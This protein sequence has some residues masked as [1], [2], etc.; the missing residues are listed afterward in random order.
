M[1]LKKNV[2]AHSIGTA[3]G[4]FWVISTAFVAVFPFYSIRI[5]K[6]I[7]YGLPV[8]QLGGFNMTVFGFIVGGLFYIAAGWI[9]GYVLERCL[10]FFSERS[11]NV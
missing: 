5:G 7:S 3:M 2:L 6:Y 11:K 9:F 10:V 8:Q 1:K 4:I